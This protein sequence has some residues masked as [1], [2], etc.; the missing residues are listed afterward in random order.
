[1]AQELERAV[2]FSSGASYTPLELGDWH[3]T[4]KE[5]NFVRNWLQSVNQS[6]IAICL[7]SGFD[8][9]I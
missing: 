6:W 3:N 8:C 4:Q 2:Q 1:V 9:F 5:L 7:T